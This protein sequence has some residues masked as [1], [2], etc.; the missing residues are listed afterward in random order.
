MTRVV[1]LLD[2]L[3]SP[4]SC[5]LGGDLARKLDLTWMATVKPREGWW[6]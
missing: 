5:R 3:E 4:H 1:I 6:P 2:F